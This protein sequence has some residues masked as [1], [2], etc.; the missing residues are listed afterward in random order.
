MN[1]RISVSS[2]LG[3]ALAAVAL[4]APALAGTAQGPAE[5]VIVTP[6]SLTKTE[7]LDFGT[8]APGLTPGVVTINANSGART[9]TGGVTLA[10]G[11]PRRAEFVGI[12]RPGILTIVSIGPAPVV[13]NGSGGTMAT[14]LA[15]EGGILGLYILPG[16]GVQTFRVGGTLAVG[17]MQA[18]GYYT[19]NFTFTVNYL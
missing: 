5:A 19:G 1:R 2:V 16:T 18:P 11:S 7:D 14:T 8:L 3:L 9:R 13:S 15:V 4:P 10:G 6:L 17:A 12:G